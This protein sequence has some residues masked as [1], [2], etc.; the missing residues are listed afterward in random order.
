[1]YVIGFIL[2][3][4]WE[5]KKGHWALGDQH[6]DY[7]NEKNKKPK[8]KE[9]N[10]SWLLPSL[11]ATALGASTGI[12]GIF[13]CVVLG[14]PFHLQTLAANFANIPISSHGVCFYFLRAIVVVCALIV[15]CYNF[16]SLEFLGLIPRALFLQPCF[17][18]LLQFTLGTV[19]SRW[20][21]FTGIV[22]FSAR[23]FGEG[24]EDVLSLREESFVNV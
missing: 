11:L 19:E 5:P 23:L 8:K 4:L 12:N 13:L 14:L 24:G 17:L 1:M 20:G 22:W 16:N 2:T 3:K 9:K 7:G 15:L 21:L 18:C 10:N 6:E